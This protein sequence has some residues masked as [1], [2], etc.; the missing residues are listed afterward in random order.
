MS[1]MAYKVP[2]IEVN[3][4][5]INQKRIEA[6]NSDDLDKLPIFEPGLKEVIKKVRGKN[7]NFNNEVD[8]AISEADMIFISVNTPIKKSGLGAGYASDLRYVEASARRIAKNATG[9]TI[10][11]EKSTLPVKTA[12]TI[13]KILFSDDQQ[14]SHKT[15]KSFSVLS[16]PEF[17]SEGNA[18]SDLAFP[19]RVLIGG[20]DLD[21]MNKLKEIYLNWVDNDKIIF[22][23]LWS[24]ELSKLTANAFL[25]QRISSMNSISAICE[26]T[27]GNI[28]EV[29]KAIGL[30]SRIGEKFLKAGPGFGG[31][32]FKKDILNLVY[33]CRSNNLDQVADYWQKVVEINEWQKERIYKKV[34]CNLFGNVAGKKIVILGFAFKANT[35][36]TRESPSIQIIKDLLQ[37]NAEII[38]N[39]P[40]V[41]DK[42]VFVD[43]L[44]DENPSQEKIYIEKDVYK[45]SIGADAIILLT[46]WDEYKF[47]DWNKISSIMNQPAWLFD[48]RC[49]INKKEINN[50]S[51]NFWQLGDGFTNQIN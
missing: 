5:D 41:S 7:L 31:S 13:K 21:A 24:S 23:N 47:L 10:V 2:S 28:S 45:A 33:L 51:L 38:I 9:H 32:C 3:V 17:L 11:V 48:T 46:E 22:S 12:E 4:V 26:I 42:Q 19:D 49:I 37:E 27:G 8:K 40:K 25:A 50:T 36:D 6:W 35:N 43:L 30:D 29:E 1:F 44:G 34:V 14:S 39:D 15:K 18:I 20:E 16:N